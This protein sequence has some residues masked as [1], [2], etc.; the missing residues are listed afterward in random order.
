MKLKKLNCDETKKLRWWQTQKV[1]TLKSSN[2][3]KTKKLK[4]LQN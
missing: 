2:Y 3:D 1:T 4:L